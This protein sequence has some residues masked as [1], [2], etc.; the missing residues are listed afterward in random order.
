MLSSVLCG[1]L[2][3][4]VLDGSPDLVKSHVLLGFGKRFSLGKDVALQ[5]D[6]QLFNVL[7][8]TPTNYFQSLVLAEGDEFVPNSW[9]RPRRLQLHVGIEF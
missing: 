6:L 9:V 3:H 2:C 5:A 8:S 1:L 7:N 4:R